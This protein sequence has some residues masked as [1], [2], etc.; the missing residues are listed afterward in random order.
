MCR[1]RLTI[2]T[3][4]KHSIFKLPEND[5]SFPIYI[6]KEQIAICKGFFAFM[7]VINCSFQVN[8]P[9]PQS[10]PLPREG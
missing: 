6:I 2:A 3:F 9:S 1:K 10:S 5:C 4:V 7:P 8:V